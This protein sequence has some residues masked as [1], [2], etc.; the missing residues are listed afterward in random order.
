MKDSNFVLELG[1][2]VHSLHY[3]FAT[4]CGQLTIARNGCTD[5][6]GCIELFRRIDPNV[7]RIKTF[8]G[9]KADTAYAI[10]ADGQWNAYQ[11]VALARVGL[12]LTP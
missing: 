4:G 12:E 8:S 5:M 7:R 9:S 3:D 10:D 11:P 2:F 1:C 6:G